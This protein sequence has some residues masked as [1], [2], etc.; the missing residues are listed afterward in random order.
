MKLGY[1][2]YKIYVLKKSLKEEGISWTFTNKIIPYLFRPIGNLIKK[3]RILMEIRYGVL[4]GLESKKVKE[5]ELPTSKLVQAARNFWYTNQSGKFPLGNEEISR[6]EIFIHG[7]PNPFLACPT[8]QRSE[9]LSRAKQKNLFAVHDCPTAKECQ[10]LC[11]KQGNESWTH[12]H[13]NFNFLIGCNPELS[14]AKCLYTNFHDPETFLR[15]RLE[16]VQPILRRQLA[17]SCQVDVV[18]NPAGIDWKKYDFMYTYLTGLKRKFSRPNIPVIAWGHDFWGEE[19]FYQWII[20]WLK[21]DILLT[22][23]PSQWKERFKIPSSTKVV[24]RPLFPSLF[25]TRPNLKDKKLDLVV[26]GATVG[27]IYQGRQALNK[28]ISELTDRY[29]IDFSN[30]PGSLSVGWK[31]KLQV[32]GSDGGISSR[33][34]NKW[35]EYLGSAKYVI[36][37]RMK[38]P[39]LLAKYYEALGSGAIPIFPEV[40]DLKLLGI[41]PFKHYIPLSKIEGNNEKL[42]YFLDNYDKFK[43]IAEDAVN[44]YK[45]NSDRMLFDDFENLIREITNHKYPKRLIN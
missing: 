6:E 26:I 11:S 39:I 42:S 1:L 25:F 14:A 22:S 30:K 16:P 20:D 27:S 3:N 35:S 12:F 23:Y 4:P 2:N 29:K 44:W 9:W 8:C 5:L 40:P 13:Q 37:G 33:Y 38:H 18:D 41:K 36:F 45:D 24:F 28:Q 15:L 32:E 10:D 19:K 7:G 43:Y 17:L 31:G 21:P 34:L